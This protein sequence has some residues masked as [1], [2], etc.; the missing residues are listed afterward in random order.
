MPLLGDIPLIGRA[1]QNRN[2]TG[3]RTELLLLITPYVLED[4]TQVDDISR[5]VRDRFG[6]NERQWPGKP[7]PGRREEAPE[8]DATVPASSRPG[9]AVPPEKAV[10]VKNA[11]AEGDGN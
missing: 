9:D 8:G 3:N 11:A 7:D 6:R 2:K 1:F 10:P 4:A 5:A